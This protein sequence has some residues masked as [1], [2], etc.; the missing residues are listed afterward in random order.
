MNRHLR[1]AVQAFLALCV[2]VLTACGSLPAAPERAAERAEAADPGTPLATIATASGPADTRSGARLL[3]LGVYAL[4]ARIQLAE[5]AR[6]SLIVQYYQFEN[7]ATG[8]LLLQALRDAGQRGVQVRVLVDDLYTAKSQRLL[9]ALSKTPNVQVRL[10]NP[11]CCNRN[12]VLARFVASP[13]EFG[14]LNHRMHNKLFVADGVMAVVG[15][16]NIADDYFLLSSAQ[17]FIDMDAL[18]VGAVLPQLQAVF[19]AYWNSRQVWPIAEILPLVDGQAVQAGDFDRWIGARRPALQ[20]PDADFL[21]YGPIGKDLDAGRIALHWGA[22]QVIADPP[23][24]PDTMSD[25]EALATSVTMQVWGLLLAA[26]DQVELTS[27]YLVPGEKGMAAF[28]DLAR[29]RVKLTLLTNSL[30]AND[31]PLVHT[32]YVRYRK[33]LLQSGA[34]LYELSPQ[35][36]SA[37]KQFGVFGQSLGRLH[38]KT[39]AIDGQRIFLGS[40]N[41]DPRSA[42]QNTEMGVVMDSVPLAQEMLRVIEVSKTRSAYRLRLAED[43]YSVQ[44]LAMDEATETVL[45]DEPESTFWQRLYNTLMG[46]LVP[47]VLL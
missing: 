45:T 28:Q 8:R 11:F 6:R 5:R 7:D 42:T 27:P 47:E 12:G 38:S 26:K 33:R 15:G 29:R 20:L 17:N 37:G 9:L 2:A 19:D 25:D 36:T 46:P 4:D 3:P 22:A 1:W 24:K 13:H 10:Y 39:A 41:L 30:A 18:L 21:G 16:R 44:W 31:E 32:G 23:T 34:D 14:R 43:G 35:R 40:M